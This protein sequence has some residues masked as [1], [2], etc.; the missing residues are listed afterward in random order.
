MTTRIS[1]SVPNAG[2]SSSGTEPEAAPPAE[3]TGSES[4]AASGRP[5]KP[6]SPPSTYVEREPS[7]SG[8]SI[9]PATATYARAPPRR[10]A[11]DNVEPA[12]TENASHSG[13]SEPSTRGVISAPATATTASSENSSSGPR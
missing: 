12:P 1:S 4:P 9:P 6:P 8:T 13:C 3:P 2:R 11:N 7:S 5:S 10:C